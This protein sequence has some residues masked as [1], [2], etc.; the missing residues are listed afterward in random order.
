MLAQ[1][2]VKDSLGSHRLAFAATSAD[3][4]PQ[5]IDSLLGC[6]WPSGEASEYLELVRG[7]L[8]AVRGYHDD[9]PVAPGVAAQNTSQ[10]RGVF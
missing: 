9:A 4:T 8:L 7:Q 3:W 2:T 6:F 5:L 1:R 10:E